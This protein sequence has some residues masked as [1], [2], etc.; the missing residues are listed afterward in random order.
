[1]TTNPVEA[2]LTRILVESSPRHVLGQPS[3]LMVDKVV[4][5]LR[6]Q[7]PAAREAAKQ[8]AV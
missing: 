2:P 5:V 8:L 6:Q 4:T 1:M 7:V 3:R